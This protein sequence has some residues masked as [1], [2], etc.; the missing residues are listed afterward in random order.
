VPRTTALV[1]GFLLLGFASPAQAGFL[2]GRA[3]YDPTTRLFTYTYTLDNTAGSWP[4][5]E[6]SI[7]IAPNQVDYDLRPAAWAA[8]PGWEF[9]TAVS[10]GIAYPPYN[11]FG[12]FWQWYNPDG[13]P[14]GE[15]ADFSFA[16]GYGAMGSGNNY[17]L[18]APEAYRTGQDGVIEYGRTVAPVVAPE[19]TTAALCVVALSLVGV[20]G[21][22]TRRGRQSAGARASTST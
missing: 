11:E 17:F 3:E 8:P 15:R 18:F 6:L 21:G 14:V 5:T 16:S 22:V 9:R 7:L 4:V 20:V 10:G 19:P 13:L 12:T 1:A 2:T